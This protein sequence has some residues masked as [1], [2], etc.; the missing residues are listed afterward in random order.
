MADHTEEV[1]AAFRTPPERVDEKALPKDIDLTGPRGSNKHK[2]FSPMANPL[3]TKTA[4][5]AAAAASIALA[6]ALIGVI[7]PAL[8]PGSS[9]AAQQQTTALLQ[10]RA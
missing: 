4:A 6:I 7:A 2:R 3:F 5:Y 9:N 10:H 8:L 1:Q